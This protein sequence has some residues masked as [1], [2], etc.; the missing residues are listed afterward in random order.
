MPRHKKR[1]AILFA[2][3]TLGESG[4]VSSK[5]AYENSWN[6][7]ANAKA[8]GLAYAILINV[9]YRHDESRFGKHRFIHLQNLPGTLERSREAVYLSRRINFLLPL[10]LCGVRE[11]FRAI[12]VY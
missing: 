9:S 10:P 8:K 1:L 4:R 5:T 11:K 3:S 12:E 6:N 2:S 7:A